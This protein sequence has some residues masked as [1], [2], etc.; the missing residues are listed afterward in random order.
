MRVKGFN[1]IVAALFIV[2]G[3]VMTLM[4]DSSNWQWLIKSDCNVGIALA[5]AILF[6]P[7][8]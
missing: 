5:I 1:Y 3:T 2:M 4:I 6:D 7:N 8:I